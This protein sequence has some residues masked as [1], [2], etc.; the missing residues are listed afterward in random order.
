MKLAATTRCGNIART[1]E[2]TDVCRHCSEPIH[3]CPIERGKW[4]H[5]NTA[6][7]VCANDKTYAQPT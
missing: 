7:R 4:D 1:V 3:P 6:M 2:S 5:T